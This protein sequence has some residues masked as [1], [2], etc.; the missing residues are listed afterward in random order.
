[1]VD[2]DQPVDLGTI[3][4]K[5]DLPADLKDNETDR[6]PDTTNPPQNSSNPKP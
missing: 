2:D 4:I 5:I 6:F 1:M 3:D